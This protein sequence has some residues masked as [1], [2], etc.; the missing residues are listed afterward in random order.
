MDATE[1]INGTTV[2]VPGRTRYIFRSFGIVINVKRIVL[3][4]GNI[5]IIVIMVENENLGVDSGFLEGRSEGA[6]DE[7][8]LLLPSHIH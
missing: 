7:F 5:V 3:L 6:A 8:A 2:V 1:S 4:R